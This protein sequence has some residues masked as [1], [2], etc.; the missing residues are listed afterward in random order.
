[1]IQVHTATPSYMHLPHLSS[2]MISLLETLFSTSKM[3]TFIE[4]VF[5]TLADS[6]QHPHQMTKLK[7]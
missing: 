4:L 5:V 1:M 7:N 6:L 3:I 2:L